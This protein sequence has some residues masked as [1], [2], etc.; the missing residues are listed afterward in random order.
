[1]GLGMAVLGSAAIGGLSSLASGIIGSGASQSASKAQTQ[2]AEIAAATQLTMFNNA[3]ARQAPFVTA[4]QNAE[5]MLWG[6][7]TNSINNLTKTFQ[8]TMNQLAS[9]PGYQFT[10][11]QGL[12][13]TQNAMAGTQP[14]GAALKSGINYAEGLASTTFQQQFQNYLAQN[15][16]IY[17]MLSGQ[18]GIGEGAATQTG[19]LGQSTANAVSNLATG[20]GAAQ[21]AGTIGSANAITGGIGNASGSLTNAIG[22]SQISSLFGG[23]AGTGGNS[24]GANFDVG[25]NALGINS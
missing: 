16:Q 24:L 9:T 11:Q 20:A 7:G 2:A 14:G 12:Q 6:N 3:Q 18:A 4:G 15:S 10:L 13:S 17:G 25:A 5:S 1:V 8:P 22:L 23:G 21:A 19:A